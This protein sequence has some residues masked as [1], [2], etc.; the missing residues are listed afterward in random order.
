MGVVDREAPRASPDGNRMREVQRLMRR[1]C[2]CPVRCQGA[3]SDT[4]H[5]SHG[6]E[7]AKAYDRAMDMLSGR[8]P[9]DAWSCPTME[10]AP[11]E[12]DHELSELLK[13]AKRLMPTLSKAEVNKLRSAVEQAKK[14]DT[15]I[16]EAELLEHVRGGHRSKMR[17]NAKCE[18]CMMGSMRTK[19]AFKGA[20]K[21]TIKLVTANVDTLDMINKS[22]AGHRY[23]SDLI[24]HGTGYGE[25]VTAR[26]KDSITNASSF[27]KMKR[28][29]EAFTD[30]GA[31]EG[32]KIQTVRHDPGSEF[33]GATRKLMADWNMVD[34]Q[35]E[36]DR[37]TDGALIENR[38]Q[39]IQHMGAAMSLTAF[40]GNHECLEE[41][42]IQAWDEIGSTASQLLNHSAITDH[43]KRA[44]ITAAE[45]QSRG[46]VCSNEELVRYHVVGTGALLLIP[47]GKRASKHSARGVRA[48]F[49]GLDRATPGA[50]RL[51]P[52]SVRDGKWVLQ[53][54]VATKSYRVFDGEFPLRESATKGSK[55]LWPEGEGIDLEIVSLED[56]GGE[57]GDQGAPEPCAGEGASYEP[58]MIVNHSREGQ[59]EV[60]YEVKWIGFGLED[61]TWHLESDL[62]EC[63]G[64]ITDYWRELKICAA[65]IEVP[66]DVWLSAANR[67]KSEMAMQIEEEAMTTKIFGENTHPRLIALTDEEVGLLT[68]HERKRCLKGRYSC[69]IKRDGKHK[70]RIVAQDLK[71]FNKCPAAD[72]YAPTPSFLTMRLMLAASPRSIYEIH[73]TD[74]NTAYLQGFSEERCDW[75]LFYLWNAGTKTGKYYRLTGPI[76]GQQPA[77]NKWRL[78]LKKGV[79]G[80]MGFRESKN[81]PSTFYRESD[82]TRV[83]VF[84]DDPLVASKKSGPNRER[85]YSELRE[86]FEFKDVTVLG[87]ESPIDYLSM[88][89]TAEGEDTVALSNHVFIGRMIS[90]WGMLGCNPAKQ[91]IT[92][93]LLTEIAAEAEMGNFVDT[94]DHER[95]RSGV[96]EALWLAQTTHPDIAPAV[97]LLS[98]RVAKPTPTCLRALKHLV[99]Y[100]SGR[101]FCALKYGD[102]DGSGLIVWG[103]SDLAGTYAVDGELRSR[104]GVA[105]TYNGMLVGWVTKYIDGV[106]CSSAEAEIHALSEAIKMGIYLKNV[107]EEMGVQVPDRVPVMVDA[108]AAKAFAEDTLGVGRMKHLDLRSG[109]I[110][111]MKESKAIQLVKVNGL[112]N[113]ADFFTK[114]LPP[115]EHQKMAGRFAELLTQAGSMGEEK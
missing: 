9:E 108:S 50:V 56:A 40:E 1:W 64:L 62:T 5:G 106:V 89:M 4:C 36:V 81:A 88:E 112:D 11:G 95:F 96:G 6:F 12:A 54:A 7:C 87:Q 8:V 76:Y 109:W 78:K 113:L 71:K 58:E 43:Q 47:K 111:E 25:Y 75:I 101:Q 80:D 66:W 38:H 49:V 70:A 85:F 35:G 57:L 16:A 17:L 68:D 91:P 26:N 114:I 18:H 33:L 60:S 107:C 73:T 27:A 99:R 115:G 72:V 94:V 28:W 92:R 79:E 48:I 30:P 61:T 102:G 31:K 41:L 14:F 3:M 98:K 19:S 32:Y 42:T 105:A 24:I 53:P 10:P 37:H 15:K 90:E 65:A 77:G 23:A 39:I 93:D 45:E 69:T 21:K 44:G 52:Y 97:S 59:G 82:Q 103:D 20:S 86:H 22:A 74:F 63:P 51:M 67:E 83:S 2:E 34:A 55:V 104:I 46:R 100:L 84:V 29:I 13:T 110:R